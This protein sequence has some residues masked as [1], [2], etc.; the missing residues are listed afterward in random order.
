MPTFTP[1]KDPIF[2]PFCP[3]LRNV[4]KLKNVKD[5][6]GTKKDKEDVTDFPLTVSATPSKPT[7]PSM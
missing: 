3:L 7:S 2:C 5:D 1:K 4:F 6:V